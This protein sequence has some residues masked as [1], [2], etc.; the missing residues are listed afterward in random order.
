LRDVL[1]TLFILGLVPVALVRPHVGVYA[2][3]WVGYMNPH[4]LTW[5]FAYTWPFGQL[6]AIGTLIGTLVSRERR[7]IPWT[8]ATVLWLAFTA[9]VSLTSYLALHPE[10]AANRWEQFVKIQLMTGLTL[11]V[12][13]TPERIRN[14]VWVVVVSIG[15]YGIKGGIFTVLTGGRLRVWGPERTF[16]EGNNELALAL[17]VIVPLMRY[18]QTTTKHRWT[19]WALTGAMVLCGFSILGSQS[20]GALVAGVAMAAALVYKS[21][22]RVALGALMALFFV[23]VWT[24]APQ[25]WHDRMGTIK[26]YEEDE[27][28]LGRINAWYFAVNLASDRP[29][30]GGG[31]DAFSADLFL[32]YAPDPHDFHDSHSIYF[33]VL[34]EHG[35]VGL[36][37]FLAL[38]VAAVRLGTRVL[39]DTRGDPELEWAGELASMIQV[40]L[41]GFATGGAFL[42][43]AYFDL[44]YNLIALMI[45]IRQLT[46]DRLAERRESEAIPE[47][48]TEAMSRLSRATP[49]RAG[50]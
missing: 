50:S 37:L 22:S 14:V 30:V 44:P 8:P 40:S 10:V 11:L 26:E 32:E 31:F 17:I 5:S 4:R 28:A 36:L 7:R 33:G 23:V 24:F 46:V 1:L 29:I 38:G 6:I 19:R 43:L 45:V 34:G 3:Y 42:G 25:S 35:Y 39:K 47:P 41:L 18:L 13:H 21:R 12:I 15:F 27:S 20:R 9:W 2:W 48:V 49:T 16:I